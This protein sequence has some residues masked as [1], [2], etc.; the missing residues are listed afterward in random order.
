MI[1]GRVL[2]YG[3]GITLALSFGGCSPGPG[4]LSEPPGERTESC[5]PVNRG[6]DGAWLLAVLDN[7]TGSEILLKSLVLRGADGV[8]LREAF[9]GPLPPEGA[10][11]PWPDPEPASWRDRT[12]ISGASIQPGT[13]LGTVLR[14]TLE[15]D[16]GTF[17]GVVVRY[18]HAGVTYEDE[19][20]QGGAL[21]PDCANWQIAG[22]SVRDESP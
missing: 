6:D 21:M 7:D 16:S 2:G 18:Q 5:I 10:M 11:G 1:L 14:V 13:M 17:S 8:N 15:A 9:V 20:H 3:L 4:P 12:P 19:L 22:S